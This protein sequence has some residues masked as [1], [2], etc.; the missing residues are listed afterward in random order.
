M[1]AMLGA[2]QAQ[3]QTHE[4]SL[5]V[6]ELI[7]WNTSDD[8]QTQLNYNRHHNSNYQPML[9]FASVSK[10]NRIL[11][12]QYGYFTYKAKG[13][14]IYQYKADQELTMSNH[15]AKSHT[16]AIRLGI[17]E[18]N[19][20]RKFE[21]SS[22]IYLPLQYT[23]QYTA[24]QEYFS[25]DSNHTI[26]NKN[27]IDYTYPNTVLTGLYISQSVYYPVFKN[28]YVGAELNLGLRMSV[29]AGHRIEKVE[30]FNSNGTSSNETNMIKDRALL[31]QLDW[32]PAL[33]IKYEIPKGRQK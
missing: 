10:K 15:N 4:L 5:S 28:L 6:Y 2:Y 19:Q 32:M 30:F 1:L 16:Q 11:S 13:N 29:H 26:L 31:M 17:G 27:I 3:S 24:H 18:R 23:Y 14:S 7:Q 25:I 22:M 33:S 20:F 21:L 8:G 12:V 9:Q